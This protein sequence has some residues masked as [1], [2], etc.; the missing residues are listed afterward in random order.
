M[1]TMLDIYTVMQK[2]L[3]ELMVQRGSFR[4][5]L[6]NLL[7][8]VVICGVIFPLQFGEEFIKTPVGLAATAWLPLLFT[9]SLIAD[10]IAGE[11]ERHT[12]E[13]LLASRLSDRA[14]LFGKVGAVVVYALALTVLGALAG[15]LTVNL[16]VP[17]V[18]FYPLVNFAGLV[19]FC[20]LAALT[21]GGIGVLVSLHSDSVRQAYQRMSLGF[22]VIWLPLILGPQFMPEQ[23]KVQIMQFFAHITGSQLTLGV[24]V[25][26]I[27]AAALFNGLALAQF[28]RSRLVE[29]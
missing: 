13:T 29:G 9:M 4:N 20:L 11:R 24:L 8:A 3:K 12:L 2:E 14:I 27:A 15:A 17:G 18:G 22:F 1:V 28:Q 26:L 6:T 16:Q 19:V 25:V 5:G 7:V 23:W 10:S 21:I